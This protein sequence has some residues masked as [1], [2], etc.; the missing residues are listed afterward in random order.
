MRREREFLA[1][2]CQ[3]CYILHTPCVAIKIRKKN[4]LYSKEEKKQ[5]SL[6]QKG[7]TCMVVS[8]ICMLY[9]FV[10]YIGYTKYIAA[11]RPVA[12]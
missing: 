7:P 10:L 11:C 12:K 1:L 9:R 4:N 8:L 3:E 5:R 2:V 6:N